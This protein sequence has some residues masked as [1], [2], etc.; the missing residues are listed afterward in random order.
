MRILWY[1]CYVMH[2]Q[3]RI[4]ATANST[5]LAIESKSKTRSSFWISL[6]QIPV[7]TDMLR[8][9]GWGPARESGNLESRNILK[10][11]IRVAK[12]FARSTLVGQKQLPATC[13]VIWC[14]FFHGPEKCKNCRI[15]YLPWWVNGPY[16]SGLRKWLQYFW[17]HP[18]IAAYY[19]A[20]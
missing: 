3:R 4:A 7:A 13:G 15:F 6:F 9:N 2:T 10:I 20:A 17:C 5:L 12:M 18:H 14:Q 8:Q 1:A 11:Q 16:S 19:L